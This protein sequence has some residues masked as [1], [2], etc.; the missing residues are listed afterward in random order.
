MAYAKNYNPNK[1]PQREKAREDQVPNNAG[2]FV[3]KIKPLEQLGRFLVLGSDSPTYYTSARELTRQ[4]GRVVEQC[5]ADHPAETAS[6]IRAFSEDGRAPR[7]DPLLFALALGTLA[8]KEETRA[9]VYRTVVSVCRIPTHLFMW[10]KFLQ[11]LGVGNGKGKV[12]AYA[13]WLRNRD[14]QKLAYA[15]VK[16]QARHGFSHS[17]IIHKSNKGA[18]DDVQRATLYK[19]ARGK[20]YNQSDLPPVVRSM[21]RAMASTDVKVWLEEIENHNLPW[22]ALPTAARRSP[23]VWT[24]LLPK[25]G[26]TALI[27]NLNVMT[28]V[29]ALGPMNPNNAVAIERLTNSDVLQKARIHPFNVLVALKTYASGKGFKGSKTWNPVAKIVDAL[30]EAFYKSFKFVEPSGKRIMLAVDVSGSMD[31]FYGRGDSNIMGTNLTP[32]EAAGAMTLIT[33]KT[34]PNTMVTAFS[35][36]I[37]P[38]NLSSRQRLDDVLTTLSLIPMGSTN[39]AAPM[40]YAEKRNIPVDAFVIYTDNETWSGGIHPYQALKNYRKAMSIPHAKLI[41]VAFTSTGFSIADPTD[42]NMLDIVGFDS[43]APQLISNF[44][45]SGIF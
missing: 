18:G 42:P 1:T 5:W 6:L 44:V 30:D 14:T 11:Q 33:E 34:E 12:R 29:G 10:A 39:C 25:M 27:R 24:A 28:E 9:L 40:Q 41:V 13:R 19:W 8:E 21:Q 35:H 4:N 16:Y 22:E 36:E 23:E 15:M 31:G 2:G 26:M 32:R 3:F 45:R 37:V 20:D 38:V 7:Q 17:R 43:A